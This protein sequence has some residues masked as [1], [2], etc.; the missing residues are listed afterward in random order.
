M[1]QLKLYN[2]LTNRKACFQSRKP[3]EV[4]LFTCGPSV[5]RRQHLG[6]YRTYLYEDVLHKFY[7]KK[8]YSA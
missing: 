1:S 7:S 6:N 3:G 8:Q 2:T 5:Y 4:K